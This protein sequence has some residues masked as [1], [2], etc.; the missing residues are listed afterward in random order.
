MKLNQD[1]DP[2]DINEMLSAKSG[3]I[4]GATQTK[5]WNLMSPLDHQILE[6]FWEEA[7]K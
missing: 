1:L 5:L 7:N 3:L 4:D 2:A 6:E